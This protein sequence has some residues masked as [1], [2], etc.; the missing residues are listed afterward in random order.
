MSLRVLVLVLLMVADP[1]LVDGKCLVQDGRLECTDACSS[2][3]AQ[4]AVFDDSFVM[5]GGVLDLSCLDYFNIKRVKLLEPIQ[6]EGDIPVGVVDPLSFCHWGQWDEGIPDI[7][8]TDGEVVVTTT[9]ILST[10]SP[11]LSSSV[12][13]AATSAVP[14]VP[15][16]IS[17]STAKEQVTKK[18]S[19]LLAVLN[20]FLDIPETRLFSGENTN[21]TLTVS[22]GKTT[23][24]AEFLSNGI[25]ALIS[26]LS[27]TV[28]SLVA[29][30]VWHCLRKKPNDT[31][32]ESGVKIE[33]IEMQDL[34]KPKTFDEIHSS[35]V[36]ED[37]TSG[38]ATI[39]SRIPKLT[40]FKPSL[41]PAIAEDA[42]STGEAS[43]AYFW[44]GMTLNCMACWC[45]PVCFA[46][47]QAWFQP[48]LRM[49]EALGRLVQHSEVQVPDLLSSPVPVP[50]NPPL[51]PSPLLSLD[52]ELGNTED[53]QD[54][55]ALDVSVDDFVSVATPMNPPLSP[56]PL[57]SLDEELGNTEDTQDNEALDVSVDDFVSVANILTKMS[58]RVLVLVLLMVAD[59]DLVDGKCSVQDG[60]L[61]CTDACSSDVAQAAAFDDSFVMTGG[62]L[63][64]S[65]LDYFNI[66]RVEL[67]E[68]IQCEGDIPIG[69]IN[70]P[71][72]CRGSEWDESI[73]DIPL[74]DGEVAFTTAAIPSTTSLPL[75]SSV[76]SAATSAVPVIISTLAAKE[77]VTK[78][79]S[80]LLAVL[81]NFSDI[82][83]TRLFS[84][85]NTNL[86][87]TVSDGKT[88]LTAEFLSNG[89]I[90]LISGLSFTVLSLVAGLVWHC[91]RKKAWFQPLLR[92][93]EA[94][95]RLA[96]H[97]EV[98][99]PDLLASPVPVPMNPPLSPS[100]L[101]SLDE[102]LGNTEDTQD[103]EAL[104]VSVDDFVSVASE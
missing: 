82:P 97:L 103:N 78:K 93:L 90:A 91:L 67:L 73:P 41:V 13:S 99:V 36:S 54:N 62:V 28:L 6:C 45:F 98:Q 24:T 95:G 59:P 9:T 23:L 22:D 39:R 69:V 38:F 32:V 64:L 47:A 26:G 87:L 8:L 66:K 74:T 86:T 35:S 29:G 17:T 72:F 52:E 33:E 92:M 70:P 63:D 14:V 58:L 44:V 42:G 50:M 4:A 7:P 96:Q 30:L 57:L 5:T 79:P 89:I 19:I 83:E 85:E 12:S 55:E 11:L 104:D 18:P 10:T 88:T 16:I 53:T 68:P 77:Q 100:Q 31:N 65:C 80:I 76:S 27:F 43:S 3:V 21:L 46:F 2:D 20:N 1:D 61:E 49:L 56:S 102:E 15:V 75:S 94:L 51:S 84:G 40:T 37:S 60:R 101:L 48:L 71:S 25:I 34:S 81:N